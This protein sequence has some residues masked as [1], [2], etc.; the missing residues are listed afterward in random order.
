MKIFSL[1]ILCAL[2]FHV[3]AQNLRALQ[4]RADSLEAV[5]DEK[6]AF[7][8]F[9]IIHKSYPAN[10]YAV[11]RC[12]E[13]CS[14]I[15]KREKNEKVRNSYYSAALMYAKRAIEI[16]PK[17]DEAN[18]SMAIALG[19]ASLTKS[20]KEKVSAAR[21][22]RKHV[23]LALQKNP[24]NFKAWHILGKWHYEVSDLNIF[25]RAALR[26]FYGGMPESSLKQSIQAYEK[27][28]ELKPAFLL[29]YLELAKAYKRNNESAKAMEMLRMLLSFSPATEDDP[30]IIM[31]AKTL[32]RQ[33]K[34]S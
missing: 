15:G 26:V 10:L 34:V 24:L 16:D 18:V 28:K 19:R 7:N 11:T 27:A 3:P 17:D 13:L 23:E 2:S 9:K 14:R 32:L 31:E 30:L 4:V 6:A 21:E 5:P 12:S 33:W 22:I 25:E 8:V 29:N 20:G 1:I